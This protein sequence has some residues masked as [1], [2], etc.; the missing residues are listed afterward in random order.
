MPSQRGEYRAR[1][2]WRP[3]KTLHHVFRAGG[4]HDQFA[5]TAE[6]D[7]FAVIHDGHA[8][9]ETLGFVH[10]VRGEKDSA[11]GELELLD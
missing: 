10:V 9:A 11:A 6:G 4:G 2:N 3:R 5:R 8:L 7:L 1:A